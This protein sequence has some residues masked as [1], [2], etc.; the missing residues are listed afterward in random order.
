[1][2]KQDPKAGLKSEDFPALNTKAVNTGAISP[3]VLKGGST[4]SKGYICPPPQKGLGP[5]GTR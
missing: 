4:A 1:M 2:D 5:K 3:S